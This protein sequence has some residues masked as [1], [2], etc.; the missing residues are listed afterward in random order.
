MLD[1][2]NGMAVFVQAVR[3]G[4]FTAAAKK[5]DMSPQ[6]VAKHIAELERRLATRLLNRTT[7]KQT[8]TEFGRLY[9]ETCQS[10]LAEV[11]GIE[12]LA[13]SAQLRPQG[14]LRINAPVVFGRYGLVPV[15]TQ[16]LNHYPDVDV[17]LTL[18]DRLIDLA[19]EGY[20]AVVRLGPLDQ[21]LALVARPLCAYRL[22]VCA[23]PAYLRQHGVPQQPADLARHECL[24]FAPW[25]SELS[26]TWFF[27]R[28]GQV[29]TV[30]VQGRLRMNDWSALRSA[31]RDGFGVLLGYEHAVAEDLASGDLIQILSEYEGP[32]RPIHLLYA[33]ERQMTLK[34]RC[35]VDH[36]METL[37]Q[38][39]DAS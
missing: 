23:A 34:L 38:G 36:V 2:L 15:V 26:R 1:R 8:L 37:G 33:A 32:S 17:E 13:Q 28:N 6:M 30:P 21:N 7:R 14:R 3:C 27:Q 10:V 39:P 22:L 25:G 4:S 12:M 18:S 11:D 24:G 20:E 9:L 31:A 16:F 35:F 5:L 19:D 29:T